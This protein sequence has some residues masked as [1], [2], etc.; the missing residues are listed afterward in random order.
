[1]CDKNIEELE[2]YIVPPKF[3]GNEDLRTRSLDAVRLFESLMFRDP[4]LSTSIGNFVPKEG[5]VKKSVE[6]LK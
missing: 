6:N 3:W 4:S 2:Q 1:M 5:D